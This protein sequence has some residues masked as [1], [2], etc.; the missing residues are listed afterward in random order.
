MSSRS[1]RATYQKPNP[2]EGSMH[3]F[4]NTEASFDVYRYGS[5]LYAVVDPYTYPQFYEIRDGHV[6][7]ATERE[8]RVDEWDENRVKAIATVR[9]MRRVKSS[10]P[11]LRDAIKALDLWFTCGI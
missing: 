11:E 1:M 10:D 4:G 7:K 3:L 9:K 2:P 6:V 5:R 8:Y